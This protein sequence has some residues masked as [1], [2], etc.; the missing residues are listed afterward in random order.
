VS[1]PVLELAQNLIPGLRQGADN[2]WTGFCP[3]HGEVPG[4]ST[5]SFSINV[6]TG[7]WICFAGC[8]G[9]HL[10]T[11][12]HELGRSRTSIDLTMDRLDKHL[13]KV[14]K[15]KSPIGRPGLFKAQFPLPERIL[16]LFEACPQSLVDEGFD[17]DLLWS[18]DVGVD[19]ERDWIT[20]P[21][22]D[23]E[24]TLAGIMGRTKGHPKYKV[25]RQELKDM[26]FP[27]YTINNHDYLWRWDI[28][29]PQVIL[30]EERPT[31]YLCEGF[32]AALWMVQCGYELTLAT[33]GSS[34]SNTQKIFLERLGGT[35]VW[36]SD[37]D[38]AGQKMVA[39]GSKKVM[40]LRQLVMNYPEGLGRL[41]PDSLE[42]D[43]LDEALDSSLSIARWRRRYA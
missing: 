38:P 30:S 13:V 8:G 28:V 36:C 9:G 32:K 18:H 2:N 31:I 41:Q 11:L 1:T 15:K 33:M 27:G 19:P 24:G 16:G 10:R 4:K 3:I 25:Y 42:P 40:G 43:E 12:L 37:F 35:L 17:E 23:I 5:P 34:L 6:K 14:A 7:L 20:Y 39:K 21:I 22:R 29:Y 26:G